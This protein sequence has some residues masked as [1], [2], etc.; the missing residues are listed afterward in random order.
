MALAYRG[1]SRQEL[2]PLSSVEARRKHLFDTYIRR[3]FKRRGGNPRYE[4]EQTIHWLTW[5]AQRM[6]QHSQ[7]VFL[8]ESLQISWLD[9][10]TQLWLYSVYVGLIV[11]LIFGLSFGL[12]VGLF[13]VLI[14]GLSFALIIGLIV[15]LFFG[16]FGLSFGLRNMRKNGRLV[17]ITPVEKL[18]WSWKRGEE[19]ARV[20]GVIRALVSGVSGGLVG[21]LIFGLVGELS[22]IRL[23]GVLIFGLIFMLIVGGRPGVNVETRTIP[24]QGIWRS[25]QTA[26]FM[27]L[28]IGITAGMSVGLIGGLSVGPLAGLF[29]GLLAGLTD[30]GGETFVKHFSLRFVLYHY[31]HIPWN[32]IGFLDYA[33][34]RIFLRKVGGGYIFIHRLLMEHFA[35]LESER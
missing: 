32:Y 27:T 31:D 28:S 9:T 23:I 2:L 19:E 17:E 15:W 8:L 5:L 11:W 21:G 18:N 10:H 20:W 7:A 22:G 24:N 33:A 34:E 25:L 29:F 4:P 35:E 1:M 30:Y 6:S 13:G 26:V 3:M 14:S 16:L 12:I